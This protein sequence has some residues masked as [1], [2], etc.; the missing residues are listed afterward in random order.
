M[1]RRESLLG[2]V[3][4]AS[5][6]SSCSLVRRAETAEGTVVPPQPQPT[7]PP[8]AGGG[9]NTPPSVSGQIAG[10]TRTTYT[11][12]KVPGP[13]IALTFDDGPHAQH[14]PRLLS[15]L[16]ERNVKAT[17]FLIGRNVSAFPGVVQRTAEEGHEIANHTQTHAKLSSLSDAGVAREIGGCDAAIS[18]ALGGFQPPV[19]RPPYGAITARQKEWVHREFGYPTIMW[20]CDPLD[21]KYRNTSRVASEM[22][23]GASRGGILLAHDIHATTVAAMPQVVDSLLAKGYQ[24]VTMSQLI[25]LER[26]LGTPAPQP[27]VLRLSAGSL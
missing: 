1:T 23:R 11:S 25:N 26:G 3:G 20:S 9:T 4:L 12:C 18:K 5:G 22:I 16:R 7:P 10:G 13:W 14:T 24:F 6:L 21:W 27:M 17:F 15:I 2:M 8:A 19:F